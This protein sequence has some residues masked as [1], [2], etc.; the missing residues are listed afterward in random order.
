VGDYADKSAVAAEL[1]DRADDDLE[2]FGIE[3]A[4]PLI[5]EQAVEPVF[6]RYSEELNLLGESEGQR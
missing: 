4:E 2:R 1:L 3:R 6:L 5:E